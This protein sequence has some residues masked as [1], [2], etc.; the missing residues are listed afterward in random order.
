MCAF[1]SERQYSHTQQRQQNQHLQRPHRRMARLSWPGWLDWFVD[2]IATPTTW[3]PS[4]NLLLSRYIDRLTDGINTYNVWEYSILSPPS[5]SVVI[6]SVSANY[7]SGTYW[8]VRCWP[9]PHLVPRSS[10]AV[11]CPGSDAHVTMDILIVSVTYLLTYLLTTTS[12]NTRRDM[13]TCT[14][15]CLLT[16]PSLAKRSDHEYNISLQAKD[17]CPHS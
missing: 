16:S 14:T 12:G 2:S 17:S 4:C 7:H 5:S 10:V 15:R 6:I 1:R 11:Q 3:M 9:V 13:M 8:V